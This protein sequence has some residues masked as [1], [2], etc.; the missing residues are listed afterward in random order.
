M[1][2]LSQHNSVKTALGVCAIAAGLFTRPAESAPGVSVDCGD[3]DGGERTGAGPAGEL[4]RIPAV[5]VD[6]VAGLLGDPGGGDDPA[7]GA[8]LGEIPGEPVATG[9]G[10]VDAAEVC[11]CRWPLADQWIA[12]TWT[13]ADGPK[14]PALGAVILSHV[15]HRDGVLVHIHAHDEWARWRQG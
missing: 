14:V 10:C 1:A 13:R 15:S 5:G 8:F 4:H 3:I 12:V 6:A 11:G 2:L 7:V 9:A